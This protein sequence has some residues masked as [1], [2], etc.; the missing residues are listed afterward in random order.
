MRVLAAVGFFGKY[1]ETDGVI[2]TYRHLIPLF[3]GQSIQ[4]D[5]MCNGPRDD[6]EILAPGVRLIVH[7]PRIPFPLDTER[8]IDPLLLVEASSTNRYVRNQ[9]YDLVQ[10]STP[11]PTG[12]VALHYARRHAV[13][14]VG[15]YHTAL[16]D[17]A[18]IRIGRVAG[19]AL[20]FAAAQFM[21]AWVGWYYRQAHLV[22]APSDHVRRELKQ[23]LTGPVEI[24]SRGVD[25]DT[26]HPRFRNRTDNRVRVL[27][28][29]RV[30]P[31]KNL[32][33]LERLFADRT[34]VDLTIVGAGPYLDE[35][36]RNLPHATCTGKLNG[37]V[38]AEAYA[39]ADIFAFPSRTDTLGNVVLEAMASGLPTV[40]TND[41]G[42]KELVEHGVTGFVADSDADFGRRLDQL[43]ADR[44]LRMR[45]G[46][47]ARVAAEH[48]TW[49]DVFR[50]LVSFYR[51]AIDAHAGRMPAVMESRSIVGAN[52]TDPASRHA[53]HRHA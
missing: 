14:F 26:F 35:I 41:M 52:P 9:H 1:G 49:M 39:S 6:L 4:L 38:L 23:D 40:V 24:L 25:T 42:P 17:Y 21:R 2:N 15:V 50:R 22:L 19:R 36:K 45:M 53:I 51:M 27:F 28:V 29:G 18:A 31:E 13:P 20:G 5:L 33:L 48:R 10:S 3:A 47:A 11:D 16:D 12:F 37:R 32:A 8:L 34:D 44:N 7:R 30:A 46:Q 43:I